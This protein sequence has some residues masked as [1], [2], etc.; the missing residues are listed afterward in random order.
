MDR[1]LH[2][3]YFP[4]QHDHDE[5]VVEENEVVAEKKES[6][7]VTLTSD[8]GANPWEGLKK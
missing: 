3:E 7:P 4:I 1:D 8:D 2:R 6:E 5:L